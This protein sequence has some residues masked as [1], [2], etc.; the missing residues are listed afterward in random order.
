MLDIESCKNLLQREIGFKLTK[1]FK[2]R[3]IEIIS[4]SNFSKFINA[5]I[6]NTEPL[7][8]DLK[9]SYS[10]TLDGNTRI[11]VAPNTDD[12]SIENLL[13]IDSFR[14]IGVIDYHGKGKNDNKWLIK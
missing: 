6:D 9:G 2:K 10:M 1:A 4:F 12:L 13:K 7:Y 5:H 3:Y 14:V 8:G 11:V